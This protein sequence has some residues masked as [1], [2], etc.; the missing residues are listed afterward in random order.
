MLH[1]MAWWG[2]G[3]CR[4]HFVDV[5]KGSGILERLAQSHGAGGWQ[6]QDRDAGRLTPCASGAPSA[7][8]P[9]SLREQAGLGSGSG[10]VNWRWKS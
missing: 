6:K 9:P 10:T 1:K 4:P 5:Q 8:S 7:P 3:H 2:A